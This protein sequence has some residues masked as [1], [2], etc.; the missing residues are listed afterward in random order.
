MII[1]QRFQYN[2]FPYYSHMLQFFSSRVIATS[3]K[4][5]FICNIRQ[6][7][8]HAHKFN[9]EISCNYLY[10]FLTSKKKLQ[11]TKFEEK[12]LKCIKS[13]IWILKQNF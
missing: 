13:Y 10:I 1:E 5:V 9:F 11:F 3:D 7:L 4:R 2:A 6:K 12:W 8:V